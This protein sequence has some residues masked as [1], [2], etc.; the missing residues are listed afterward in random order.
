MKVGYIGLKMILKTQD[1]VFCRSNHLCRDKNEFALLY[2]RSPEALRNVLR[3]PE[4]GTTLSKTAV[5]WKILEK[6]AIFSHFCLN[7][8]Q[9]N[10]RSD[11]QTIQNHKSMPKTYSETITYLVTIGVN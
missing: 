11:R 8:V 9:K 2:A 1:N 4:V 10:C 5:I 6:T 7:Y 3:R